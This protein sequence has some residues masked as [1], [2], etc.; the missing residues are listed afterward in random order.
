M[1]T[2]TIENAP[3]ATGIASGAGHSQTKKTLWLLYL[4]MT[5][6]SRHEADFPPPD[7][8]IKGIRL[9]REWTDAQ[10]QTDR[11]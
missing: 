6:K 1:R 4:R 2:M 3:E 11:V 9:S 7:D 8:L 10:I 5:E